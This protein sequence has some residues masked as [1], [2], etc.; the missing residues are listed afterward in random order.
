MQQRNPRAQQNDTARSGGDS[1]PVMARV[2]DVASGGHDPGRTG[3]PKM[4]A[5]GPQ[6]QQ[7]RGTG[8]DQQD[9]PLGRIGRSKW[10][11]LTTVF[12]VAG[13]LGVPL[14][15][16]SPVFSKIEK[17]VWTTVAAVYS[18]GLL[19]ILYLT[20]IWARDRIVM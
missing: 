20:I 4:S 19:Y 17:V 6:R 3:S 2:V 11:I 8:V 1:Q 14:I 7:P 9:E 13:V 15:L 10:A 16:F 18:G 5:G 12:L